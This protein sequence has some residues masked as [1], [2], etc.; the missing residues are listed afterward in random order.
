MRRL[1]TEGNTSPLEIVKKQY[2][3]DILHNQDTNGD[4]AVEGLDIALIF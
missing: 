1:H 4:P 2:G 3:E